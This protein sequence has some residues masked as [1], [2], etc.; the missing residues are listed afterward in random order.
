MLTL[1]HQLTGLVV[2][3]GPH[4]DDTGRAPGPELGDG[5]HRVQRV[6]DVD[7]LEEARGLLEEGDERV[8][9]HVREEPGAGGGLRGDEEPV[10]EEVAVAM[11]PTVD[12][13]VVDRVVVA[14]GELEGRE[15]SLGHGARGDVEA[16][17]D[18]EVVEVP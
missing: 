11:R 12:A 7:G 5:E 14:G 8:A 10:G 3:G 4:H 1:H 6:P 2:D 13:V 9:D 17:A 18:A 15:E 16:L